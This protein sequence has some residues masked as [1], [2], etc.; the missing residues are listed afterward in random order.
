MFVLKDLFYL[1]LSCCDGSIPAVPDLN[2]I[3]LGRK[4]V[5]TFAWL[6]DNIVPEIIGRDLFKKK[7]E[8][9][10]PSAFTS[11]SS[12]AFALLCVENYYEVAL[13][14]AQLKN[15]LKMQA[16]QSKDTAQTEEILQISIGEAVYTG[17]GRGAAKYEG[18]D[19]KGIARFNVLFDF[20]KQ[21]RKENNKVDKEFLLLQQECATKRMDARKRLVR[22]NARTLQAV[23]NF[24]VVIAR[25]DLDNMFP[26]NMGT[27][28]NSHKRKADPYGDYD[29]I[30]GVEMASV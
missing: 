16:M 2:R 1:H 5:E 17:K 7:V 22:E 26:A 24:T 29:I 4:S 6:V 30:E 9:Q 13:K 10:M 23:N 3:L 12:E 11:I 14:K 8:Q 25:N 21:D 20:V 15:L 18:W 19:N 27:D 28:I